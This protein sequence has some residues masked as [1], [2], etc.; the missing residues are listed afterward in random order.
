M[1][2]PWREE[3]R[4]AEELVKTAREI[5]PRSM[6]VGSGWDDVLE[7]ATQPRRQLWLIPASAIA[8]AVGI[9]IGFLMVRT[10]PA[11]PVNAP[12]LSEESPRRS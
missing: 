2:A 1:S 3:D 5:Q 10:Q 6:D 8:V 9:A 7:R 4:R 11:D 12:F